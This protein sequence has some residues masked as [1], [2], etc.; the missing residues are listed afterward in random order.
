MKGTAGRMDVEKFIIP[1]LS[2]GCHCG[3]IKNADQHLTLYKNMTELLKKES[4]QNMTDIWTCHTSFLNRT[5]V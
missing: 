4:G 5:E 1:K 3:V 2:K